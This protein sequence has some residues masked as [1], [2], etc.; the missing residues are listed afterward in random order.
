MLK[1][2]TPGSYDFGTP[3]TQLVKLSSRGLRGNDLRDFLKLASHSLADRLNALERQPGEEPV[4][5][6]A[7]GSTEGYGANRNGDGFRDQICRDYHPTFAKFAHYFRHHDNKN[8]KKSYGRVKEAVFNE[9]MKRVEL[10]ALLNSTKEAAERNG[11]LVADEEME[12]LSRDED[13]PTSMSCRVSH[14]ICSSCQNKARFRAEYCDSSMCKHG[15]LK[16]NIGKTFADG[17]MLHADNPDPCWFDISSVVRGADRI[18]YNLGLLDKAASW[19]HE[20][21]GAAVAE[22]CGL[23][24][25]TWLWEEVANPWATPATHA[26]LKAAA[27]LLAAEEDAWSRP[28]ATVAAAFARALTT[29]A[30]PLGECA[31]M[32]KVASLLTA[33]HEANCYLPLGEFLCL[34][35]GHEKTAKILPIVAARVPGIVGRMATQPN[36]EERLA[37]NPYLAKAAADADRYLLLRNRTA[38]SLDRDRVVERLQ[39]SA[40]RQAVPVAITKLASDTA[41]EQLAEEY[42]LYTLAYLAA[43]PEHQRPELVRLVVQAHRVC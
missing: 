27:A 13:V 10:I 37:A 38:W 41:A 42:G 23:T 6:L 25:P 22:Q 3:Q 36:F 5:I 24:T 43:Q 31:D 35:A 7:L 16:E 18:S 8:P 21:C 29:A 11:N 4:L 39:L 40:V 17:H 34:L 14:D 15:G 12:K 32:S 33:A 9:E 20:K 30:V 1:V 26:Q 19:T 28:I 2:I